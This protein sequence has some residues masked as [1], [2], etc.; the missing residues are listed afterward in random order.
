MTESDTEPVY[1]AVDWGG[2]W[3]RVGLVRGHT[4]VASDK[5]ARP[6]SIASQL[7][8][9]ADT[10][11]SCEAKVGSSAVA[12]G[13]GIAGIVQGPEMVSAI[14]LDISGSVDVVAALTPLT[15]RAVYVCN[16]I[17]AVAGS[18]RHRWPNEVVALLSMGTGIGGA[19]L[20]R[21]RVFTGAGAAG[22]FGH[23]VMEPDG[24]PCDCGGRGC[25]ETVVCGRVLAGQAQALATSGASPLL[26]RIHVE[27]ELHGGDLETAASAGEG[28]ARVVLRD[29]AGALSRGLRSLVGA[30]DPH[31]IVLLGA[32]LGPDTIFGGLLRDRW[33]E[34]RP[35]WSAP[36]LTFVRDDETSALIGAAAFAA[37]RFE[38]LERDRARSEASD[39]S[40]EAP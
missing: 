18:L 22:D 39:V 1:G 15:G 23:M 21:G 14:N 36:V 29:G 5:L 25:L 40:R 38:A 24:L 4:L 8:V 3:I 27:R 35:T 28:A 11:R 26:A 33:I 16:D 17:Q 19:L 31:R 20:V 34:R 6:R 30:V 9:V 32:M 13:V 12:V 2:S 10:L 37:E 7:A